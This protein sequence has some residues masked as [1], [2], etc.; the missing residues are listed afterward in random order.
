MT[1][2][3][4]PSCGAPALPEPVAPAIQCTSCSA[5]FAVRV[6]DVE[7]VAVRKVAGVGRRRYQV[8]VRGGGDDAVF[9]GPPDLPLPPGTRP[10]LLQR[11]GRTVAIHLEG[12]LHALTPAASAPRDLARVSPARRVLGGL[13]WLSLVALALYVAWRFDAGS[14]PWVG[15]P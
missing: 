5:R 10:A 14:V 13:A 4:C 1:G 3:C 11:D 6:I 8:H 12:S 7:S 15:R 2:S 9:E